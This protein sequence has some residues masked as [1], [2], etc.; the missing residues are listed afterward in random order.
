MK[1]KIVDN[2]ENLNVVNEIIEDDKTNK[3][4]KSDYT[5]ESKT[6]EEALLYNMCDDG[7]KNL[8]TEVLDKWKYVTKN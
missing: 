6:I 5:D 4:L 7:L 3:D 2:D 1:E 8:K